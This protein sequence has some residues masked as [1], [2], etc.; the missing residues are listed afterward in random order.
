MNCDFINSLTEEQKAE[1]RTLLT[2]EEPP[3]PK[4]RVRVGFWDEAKTKIRYL[5]E[6][7]GDEF[8]GVYKHWRE[9]GQL[10]C[11]AQYQNHKR[12][13]VSKGWYEDG[14]LKYEEPY[15]NGKWHGVHKDWNEDGK[16][17]YKQYLLYNEKVSE[18]EYRKHELI[19][20]LAGI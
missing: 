10:G 2:E 1:L 14:K 11:E 15:Q 3:Q 17:I 8:H 20:Q 12:H 6:Y 9:N 5:V 4:Y 19:E 16:I 7:F 18:E 13:G